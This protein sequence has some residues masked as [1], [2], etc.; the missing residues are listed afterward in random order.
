MRRSPSWYLLSLIL[1]C[2]AQAGCAGTPAITNVSNWMPGWPAKPSQ[3]LDA[4]L[5]LG[6]LSERHGDAGTAERIYQAVLKK[7]PQNQLAHHRLGVLAAKRGQVDQAAGYLDAAARLGP[8]SGALLNDIGFNLL[9]MDR[10]PEAEA[11]FR[12]ALE[13]EPQNRSAHNNLGLVLGQTGRYEESLAQFRQAGDEAEAQANLAYC[14]TRAG[15][16]QG[17]TSAYHRALSLN[18]ELKPAAEAL[19]QLA[20]QA[21]QPEP[22]KRGPSETKPV[23]VSRMQGKGADFFETLQPENARPAQAAQAAWISGAPPSSPEM[24]TGPTDPARMGPGAAGQNA[25]GF[26]PATVFRFTEGSESTVATEIHRRQTPPTESAGGFEPGNDAARQGEP[27][28]LP[29]DRAHITAAYER[30]RSA[31]P[32]PPASGTAT[33]YPVQPAV[34]HASNAPRGQIASGGQAPPAAEPAANARGVFAG[35][36]LFPTPM[37]PTM[38]PWQAPTWTP[39]L[40]GGGALHQA[41]AATPEGGALMSTSYVPDSVR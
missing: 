30:P 25:S 10:L 16:L 3:T 36:N 4:Q 9:M 29:R 15:D 6:R 24:Q 14:K 26:I 1:A 21:P 40:G 23:R 8:P 5:S 17:A 22:A 12:R 18:Q 35:P 20:Q 19:M 33:A 38:Q 13:I 27:A 11:T 31:V 7:D 41:S 32:L 28:M 2:A 37:S 34:H 39:E